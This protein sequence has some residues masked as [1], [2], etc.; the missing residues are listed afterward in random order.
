MQAQSPALVINRLSGKRRFTQLNFVKSTQ[1]KL[2]K[3]GQFG[4]LKE[5]VH[6]IL[7]RCQ[8]GDWVEGIVNFATVKKVFWSWWWWW[9]PGVD[10]LHPSISSNMLARQ[11]T[12]LAT[13]LYLRICLIW[14]RVSKPISVNKWN[15]NMKYL[16]H[17]GGVGGH[18]VLGGGHLRETNW[19]LSQSC[20]PN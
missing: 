2:F 9:S 10:S 19:V 17:A 20:G 1:L 4:N 8:K 16:G 7:R 15:I 14:C 13:I 11:H 12:K 6:N 18:W 3:F 5:R